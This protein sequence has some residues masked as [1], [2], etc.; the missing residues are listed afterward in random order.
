[1][2][3]PKQEAERS[4]NHE[5]SREVE[6]ESRAEHLTRRAAARAAMIRK[7]IVGRRK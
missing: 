1:M 5:T 2:S 3:E 6:P 7:R 4:I